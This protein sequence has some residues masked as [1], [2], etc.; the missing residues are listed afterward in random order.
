M[1]LFVLNLPININKFII[2][3]TKN[4][5]IIKEITL[6]KS[7]SENQMLGFDKEK[8]YMEELL[9]LLLIEILYMHI[10]V[11]IHQQK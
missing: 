8:F 6:E 10:L 4:L 7:K 3:R 11:T 2:F 5:N 9:L 1:I